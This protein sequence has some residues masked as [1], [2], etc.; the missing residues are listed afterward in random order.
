MARSAIG[1]IGLAAGIVSLL[2]TSPAAT[3]PPSPKAR[4]QS[5]VV[6]GQAE[7]G[8]SVFRGVPYAAPPVGPLRW[9][10]PQPHAAWKGERVAAAFGLDCVQTPFPGDSTPSIHTQSED[11]LTLNVWSPEGAK[12]APVMVWIHG[13]G[14][15]NGLGSSPV[16]A[17]AALA[18]AG[19]VVVTLNYRL[20]RFG[21]F[22]HP[23]L[24]AEKPDEPKGNYGFMDQIAALQWVR[25][26]IAAFGGD[27]NQVTVFGESA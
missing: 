18:R 3:Q 25:A 8:L 4:T 17:G 22:A 14:F 13:G 2:A 26:N 10:P 15:T 1:R 24:S 27:P 6:V 9:R 7:S 21:F 11:C 12:A 23:A 16:F 19:V 20:G 5:G